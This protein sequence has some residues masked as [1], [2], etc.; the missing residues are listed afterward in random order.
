MKNRRRSQNFLLV[1]VSLVISLFVAELA[2]RIILP[3]DKMV[4][5]LEMHP[6]GFMMNQT[7]G[8]AF[9]EFGEIKIDYRFTENRLRDVSI[10]NEGSKKILALGD[11]FTF[12]LLLQEESSYI[13]LLNEH[14]KNAGSDSVEI[15]NGGVGGAGLA[16]WPAWLEY[17]GAN[18]DPDV[19]LYFMNIH[20]L[21]RALSKNIYVLKKDSLIKSQRWKPSEA[22]QSL[23]KQGWYRYLQGKSELFNIVVKL[24]WRNIYFEDLTNDFDTE[25]SSVLIPE[26]EDFSLE[27]EYSLSLGKA[28]FEKMDEWCVSNN[29]ELLITTTGFFPSA[30][31]AVSAHT[32]RLYNALKEGSAE[33]SDKVRFFDPSECVSSEINSDY[34][35]IKIP[36]DSHPNE[37]GAK[38]IADCIWIELK[39]YITD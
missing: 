3:Q 19:I 36:G 9:Q 35:S 14:L 28:I 27:S 39:N 13:N 30:D 10:N 2:V 5:W 11:S 29:C 1:L 22:M 6:D 37:Q 24:L 33:L 15:L 21:E 17:N 26:M 12:G 25:S 16:D 20:D 31:T 7:G 38:L 18:I 34:N 8:K 23:G 32:L 4:T